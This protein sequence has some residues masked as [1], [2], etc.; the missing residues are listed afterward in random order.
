M[1][2]HSPSDS[3]KL[4][5][6]GMWVAIRA[7]VIAFAFGLFKIAQFAVVRLV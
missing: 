7:V 3:E 2:I 1:T 5:A 6:I 4:A